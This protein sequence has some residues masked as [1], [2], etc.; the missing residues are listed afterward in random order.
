MIKETL[1]AIEMV[2]K[3]I[4]DIKYI[5]E[6]WGQ[7]DYYSQPP[8]LWP[9]V[10]L[11]CEAVDYTTLGG[12]LQKGDGVVTIRV[13]DY[14]NFQQA[15]ARTT[16]SETRYEF[17]DLIDKIHKELQGLSSITFTPL[18]RRGLSRARRDDAI[19]EFRLT[20]KFSFKDNTA[21][22]DMLQRV[23]PSNIS[24]DIKKQ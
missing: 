11:D 6:D 12:N 24:I 23:V 10:L 13:A 8:V 20:Y 19:R 15:N 3:P 21:V 5:N 18:D 7:I 2:L 4:A 9:C 22:K 1:N 16:T 14:R 17:F